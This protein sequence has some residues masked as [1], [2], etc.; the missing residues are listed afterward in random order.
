M[1]QPSTMEEVDRVSAVRE[2]WE[3]NYDGLEK[4]QQEELWRVL[5][6]FKDTFVTRKDSYPLP[7]IKESLDLV[8]GSHHGSPHS[9]C[10]VATGRCPSASPKT[11][12][13][14]SGGLWQFR[15]LSFGLCNAPATFERLMDKVLVGIHRQECLV[16]LDNILA[17]GRSFHANLGALRLVLQR[18][19][20]AGLKLNPEK[21]HF[22]GAQTGEIWHQHPGGEC[23]GSERLAHTH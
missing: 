9:T 15:V 11:T 13:S 19:A 23:A 20:A 8:A 21:C 14:T 4:W 5:C 10:A 12:F 22:W 17:H 18:V 7:R 2:I 3:C 16:Y 1:V 6:E